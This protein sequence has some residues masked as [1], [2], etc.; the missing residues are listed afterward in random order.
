MSNFE[1]VKEFHQVFEHPIKENV[2]RQIF[3]NKS[4]TDLR[5]KLIQEE[6]DELKEAIQNKD[7]VEVADALTDILYVVYGAG[8]AFGINL[9]KTFKLVHS[10]NMTKSC[11]NIEEAKETLEFYNGDTRYN[12]GYKLSKDEKRYIIYDKNTGKILKNK[13]YK[14][15]DLSF[16][17]E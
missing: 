12:S 9:D 2:D 7:I 6:F 4:L 11:E 15:V 14:P 1:M 5:L 16:L 8:H 10:S 13:N 3:E 17:K